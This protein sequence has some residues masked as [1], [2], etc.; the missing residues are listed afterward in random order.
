MRSI[1]RRFKNITGRNPFWS[2][3]ISFTEAIKGQKFS[4]QMIHRWFSKLV[5]K[6]DY[7]NKNKREILAQLTELSNCAEDNKK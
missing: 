2:S 5:A 6:D 3:F 4:A 7:D 1:E